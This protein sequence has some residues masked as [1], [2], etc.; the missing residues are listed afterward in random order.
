MLAA[1]GWTYEKVGW[2]SDPNKSTPLYRVYNP[3]AFAN[4]HFYTTSK[5]ERDYLVS[6]GWENEGIGWYGA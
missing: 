5:A 2:Y 3:N 1:V 6:I 4:N